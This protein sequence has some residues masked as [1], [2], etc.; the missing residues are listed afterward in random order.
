VLLTAGVLAA[1]V[2]MVNLSLWQLRRLD[3]R[4][5][6]NREIERSGQLPPAPLGEVLPAGATIDDLGGAP[7]RRVEVTGRYDVAH[8]VLVNDRS[9]GGLPGLHVVTPLVL[10]DGRGLLVNRGWIPIAPVVGEEPVAPDPPPGTVT[11]VGRVRPTQV[12]GWLGPTDPPDG[13]LRRVARLDV[14]RIA[15][16]TPYPL[17]P[18]YVELVAADE[19]LPRPLPLPTLGDGP[20]LSYAGQWALFALLAVGGWAALVRRHAALARR[21]ERRAAALAER[22]ALNPDAARP[23]AAPDRPAPAP[24]G[25][26]TAPLRTRG[27]SAP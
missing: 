18:A 14:S 4:R 27:P 10:A 19:G 11:I 9:L 5:T 25:P 26:T 15:R 13:N 12:R 7:W 6:A 20:H 2:V 1:V 22:A 23:P 3:E 17:V 21:A 8:Q 24:A 16:Q